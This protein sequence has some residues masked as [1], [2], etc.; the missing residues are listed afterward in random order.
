MTA[1]QHATAQSAMVATHRMKKMRTVI[2]RDVD[3]TTHRLAYVMRRGSA[4]F[5][6]GLDRAKSA[7]GPAELEE[8][9][10]GF[11]EADVSL[12]PGS[13]MERQHTSKDGDAPQILRG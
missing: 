3:G 6:C 10:V 8:R 7:S 5:V 13:P 2:V 9:M 12:D 11:P 1:R 4:I